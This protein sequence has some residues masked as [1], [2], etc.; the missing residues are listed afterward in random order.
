MTPVPQ[1][2]AVL[3]R[4]REKVSGAIDQLSALTVAENGKTLAEAKGELVRGLQYIEHACAIPEL[5]KGSVSEEIG[6]GVDTEYI[7]EPLG[8]FAI[9]APFNFPA[10]I[11]PISHGPSPVATR[12]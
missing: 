4:S 1:R 5:M 12:W 2:A 9:V 8:V 7:R 10:M 11:P 3:F 6:T